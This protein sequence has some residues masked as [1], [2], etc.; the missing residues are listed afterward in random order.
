MSRWLFSGFR[1]VVALSALVGLVAMGHVAAQGL[2]AFLMYGVNNGVPRALAVDSSGNLNISAS[3]SGADGAI[4]DGTTPGIE[5]TV[6]DLTSSNPLTVAITDGSGNQITSFGGGTQYATG[7]A[8][9]TPT[10]T[11]SLGWD[12]ANVHA[13]NT[14]AGGL[15]NLNNVSGTISLPTGASTS[16]NQTTEITA[17]QIID[18]LPLTQGS[19]T[20]GQSGL[21]IMAAVS[22]S[23]PTYTNGQT[24]PLSMAPDGSLRVSGGGGGTQYQEDAAH[25]SGDSG[26]MALAVR[27]DADT[28]LVGAS[29]DYTPLQLDA[30]GYLKVNIKAGAGS[31]GTAST[32]DAAFTVGSGSGT[33]LMGLATSDLVDSGDVGVL[34]MS[35]AR[36]LYVTLATSA[37]AEL[38][39]SADVTEDSPETANVTGPMILNV[40]RDVPIS[41]ASTT[42]DNAT[43]NSDGLGLTWSRHWSPCTALPWQTISVSVNADAVAIS[44]SAGNRNYICGGM[45]SAQAAETVSVW[46]GTGTTCGTSSAALVGSLTEANGVALAANG[47]FVI[48]NEIRG[49]T[50]NV[51]TCIR[52]AGTA[53]VAGWIG[54]VQAP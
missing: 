11:V 15:L 46:E 12:G 8:Q 26:T 31:G 38:T 10:G 52:L 27:N 44:A 9:A 23:A 24:S 43:F 53:R 40:R 3:I 49:A 16:A 17:L 21:L 22:T 32:D 1:W 7:A 28:S 47:G 48:P 14:S 19:T 29:L 20:S 41:S 25:V 50:V 4:Q 51:D 42:G 39:P 2:P 13:L 30:N 6:L 36:T 54:V 33:P 35:T 34:K 18:N 5:A 37:G 45:L